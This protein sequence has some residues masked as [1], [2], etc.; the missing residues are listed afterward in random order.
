M[1]KLVRLIADCKGCP[2]FKDEDMDVYR[3][4]KWIP[5]YCKAM[6]PHK[7]INPKTE[8]PIPG[9][10]PLEDAVANSPEPILEAEA[11]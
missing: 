1:K 5:P 2:K 4:C 11:I 9:W 6:E 7:P 10:C 3:G 8:Y